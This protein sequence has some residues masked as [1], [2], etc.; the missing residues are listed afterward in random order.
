[1]IQARARCLPPQSSFP[2]LRPSQ[3]AATRSLGPLAWPQACP[4]TAGGI[5]YDSGKGEIFVAVFG[6]NVVEVISDS[7][8]GATSSTSSS[9]S[10]NERVRLPASSVQ[11]CVI[12]KQQL[13]LQQ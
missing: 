11:S 2:R 6:S 7:S 4:D 1:M 5:A 9:P 13:K 3:R 10:L 8:T 12:G